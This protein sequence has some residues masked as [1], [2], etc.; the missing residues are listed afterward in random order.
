MNFLNDTKSTVLT[1]VVDLQFHA[2]V[3]SSFTSEQAVMTILNVNIQTHIVCDKYNI[4]IEDD[5]V[6][7]NIYEFFTL[8]SSWQCNYSET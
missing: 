3:Y 6:K 2:L 4:K 8:P 1:V 5:L 7:K